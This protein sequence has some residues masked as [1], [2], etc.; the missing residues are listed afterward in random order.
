MGVKLKDDILGKCIMS[1][2]LP[3]TSG[4]MLTVDDIN[5]DVTMVFFFVISFSPCRRKRACLGLQV[6]QCSPSQCMQTNE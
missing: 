4:S 2:G 5:L 3:F 1:N 6:V